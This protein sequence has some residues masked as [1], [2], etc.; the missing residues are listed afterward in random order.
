MQASR[1]LGAIVVFGTLTG[2]CNRSQQAEPG[3]T[4]AGSS[5]D[6]I[7]EQY[8]RLT[9]AVGQHDADYVDAYYGPP[10]WKPSGDKPSLDDL[11][12]RAKALEASPDLQVGRTPTAADEM[13][14][15]RQR[16]LQVQLAAMTARVRMLKGERLTFDEESRALYDATAPVLPE[17]HF[18]EV[19][20]QLE[21]RFPGDGPLVATYSCRPPRALPWSTSRTNRGAATTGTR[22]NFEA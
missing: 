5:M 18:Q 17:S 13:E 14:S 7:A 19:L 12:S 9:L 8:V 10:E 11:L 4:A 2:A 16:Y 20:S 6:S 22:E 1:Y 21:L 15:L 3:N